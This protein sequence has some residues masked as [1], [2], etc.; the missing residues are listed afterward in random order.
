LLAIEPNGQGVQD[1]KEDYADLGAG[2]DPPYFVPKGGIMAIA[3][4]EQIF[5]PVE[6]VT[7]EKAI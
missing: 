5:V 2:D 1:R 7:I 6:P 3:T 4:L